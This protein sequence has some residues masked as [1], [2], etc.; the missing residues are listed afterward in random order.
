MGD[1]SP[2]IPQFA[3]QKALLLLAEKRTAMTTL[4][5]GIAICL[6]PLTIVSFLA[7]MTEKMGLHAELLPL[8]F[9]LAGNG[10]LLVFGVY[11]IRRGFVRMRFHQ[12][13]LDELQVEFPELRDLFYPS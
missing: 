1:A 8:A 9:S 11:L 5:T 2:T 10:A 13:K 4:R 6:F 3:F 12:R 7:T